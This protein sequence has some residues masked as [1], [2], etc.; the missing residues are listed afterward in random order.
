M[1]ARPSVR[2]HPL[3]LSIVWPLVGFILTFGSAGSAFSKPPSRPDRTA[4]PANNPAFPRMPRKGSPGPSRTRAPARKRPDLKVRLPPKHPPPRKKKPALPVAKPVRGRKRVGVALGWSVGAWIG[5]NLLGGGV[6]AAAL[7]THGARE[8]LSLYFTLPLGSLILLGANVFGPSIGH[9]YAGA[10]RKAWTFSAVRLGLWATFSVT[11][12]I[13]VAYWQSKSDDVPTE[14]EE[15]AYKKRRKVMRALFPVAIVSYAAL[16]G[17]AIW[18]LVVTPRAVRRYNE[19]R[20]RH[21]GMTLVPVP[22]IVHDPDSG[23]ILPGFGL[24]GRF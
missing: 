7:Y 24:A 20:S 11:F 23:K 16:Y 15:V 1:A 9:F 14:E 4:F 12:G 6:V 10:S 8:V 17:A 19:K 21:T 2:P 22:M 13:S 18:E 3:A 5:G